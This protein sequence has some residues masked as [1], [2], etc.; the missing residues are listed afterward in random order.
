MATKFL[1]RWDNKHIFNPANA[2]I[3]IG[4]IILPQ[5][6]WVSPGQWGSAIWFGF[7]LVSMAYLVLNK[8]GRA[9]MALFFL[10]S[11][12]ALIFTRALW[13][14][15]PLTIPLHNAQSGALLIFAFFMISDPK[16]TPDHIG[17]RAIFAFSTA[18]IGYVLQY[19]FQV[20]EGLFFA[21]FAMSM[22]TPLIDIF[23]KS[24]RYQWRNA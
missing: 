17:G 15:D 21:L 10:S 4:L 9:D 5:S 2:A 20:R 6:V 14:G 11:W 3:V 22:T 8:A 12:F 24:K 1:I 16:S 18:A 23:L 7:A 13:L 19:H